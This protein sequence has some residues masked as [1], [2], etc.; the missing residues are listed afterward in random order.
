MVPR[1]FQSGETDRRGRISKR[2]PAILRKLLVE[3]AWCSLRYN[4][5]ARGVYLR[6][7]HK[8]AGPRKENARGGGGAGGKVVGARWGPAP[9]RR[10]VA[11]AATGVSD[12]DRNEARLSE[13]VHVSSKLG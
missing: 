2:G 1:Q 7:S 6:L 13:G 9:R 4:A 12:R 10:A 3:C 5:W 8:G 11:R